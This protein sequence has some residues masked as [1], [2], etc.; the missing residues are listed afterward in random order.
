[1]EDDF[2]HLLHSL[3]HCGAFCENRMKNEY[4][5]V[6]D[7]LLQGYRVSLTCFRLMVQA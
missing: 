3:L 5:T 6:S 7:A 4:E 1:M 2:I